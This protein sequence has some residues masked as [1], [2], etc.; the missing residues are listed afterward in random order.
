MLLQGKTAIIY[1]GG[2]SVGGAIARAYVREGARVHLV[3]RTLATLA[4]T[5]DGIP[6]AV[7]VAVVDA[8]DERAVTGHA[9]AVAAKGGIDVSVNVISDSDVQGVPILDMSVEDY[10]SPVITAVRSKFITSRAAARH[11]VRRG[12]G[13]IIAFGGSADRHGALRNYH[14]GGLQ[15]AFDAVESLRRQLAT[16]LSRH[17][18]RVITLRTSGVPE[19]IPDGP[20]AAI[21]RDIADSTLTGSPATL[22]DV[23]DVAVFAASDRAR[24]LT[25]AAI[26]MS[27]GAVLD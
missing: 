2:G 7:E 8:S 10:L 24:T 15:T 22:A 26:N 5:A 14:L 13:V 17:G 6:G 4:K 27:C 1:G 9:D 16:E 18:V 21:E 19:V 20:R 3:G 11:M 23:G 25:G 12:S